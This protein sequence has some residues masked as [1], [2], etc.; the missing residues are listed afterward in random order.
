MGVEQTKWRDYIRE[1]LNETKMDLKNLSNEVWWKQWR[2][3]FVE[4]VNNN[5]W[6]YKLDAVKDYFKEIGLEKNSPYLDLNKNWRT[7][8]MGIQIWLYKAWYMWVWHIDARWGNYTI[9]CMKKFQE[10]NWLTTTWYPNKETIKKLLTIAENPSLRG[11]APKRT[12]WRRVTWWVTNQQERVTERPRARTSV[13]AVLPNNPETPTTIES[14]DNS[15]NPRITPQEA[16]AARNE[17]WSLGNFLWEYPF[18][19]Y[20]NQEWGDKI[21]MWEVYNE[22]DDNPTFSS[23]T[24]K[25][26]HAWTSPSWESYVIF[27]N[28]EGGT[29]TDWIRINKNWTVEKWEFWMGDL[30]LKGTQVQANG[31]SRTWEFIDWRFLW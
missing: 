20:F 14:I 17:L 26:Y 15:K 1:A 4:K 24:Q 16:Q 23:D 21:F 27:G 7:S 18:Y 13:K 29:C 31:A 2:A 10:E 22:Y 3:R 9:W 28:F 12:P 30:L 8:I 11:Q 25:A 19:F 6:N 5:A